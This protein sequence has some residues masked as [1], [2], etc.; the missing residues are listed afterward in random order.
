VIKGKQG[1]WL[2]DVIWDDGRK[3]TLP[4]VS[5]RF[6]DS[7]TKR[8]AHNNTGMLKYPGA[9]TIKAGSGYLVEFFA[10]PSKRGRPG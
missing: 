9:L 5:R 1:V 4:T 6:F 7:A 2:V 10:D 3:A 8:Y